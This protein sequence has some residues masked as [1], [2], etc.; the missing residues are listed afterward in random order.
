MASKV[1]RMLVIEDSPSDVR[2]I[3]EAVRENNICCELVVA[4]D[5]VE[6]LAYL[7]KVDQGVTERPDL[8]LLDLNLPR[9]NGREVLAE[10]KTSP[11]LKQIPVLVV[12]SSRSE[13]DVNEAYTLNANCF[14]SKPYNLEEYIAVVRSIDEFWGHTATLP[15][16]GGPAP[17][18]VRSAK[19]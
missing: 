7:R 8:I 18:W 19:A 10:V 14:I 2:L 12:T 9:K 16:A 3:Q 4:R 5:G 15:E 1:L 6:G 17:C 13:D 11:G